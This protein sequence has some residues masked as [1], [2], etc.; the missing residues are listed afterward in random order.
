MTDKHSGRIGSSHAR[1]IGLA[2][3]AL[4]SFLANDP[5]LRDHIS[6][7]LV[8]TKEPASLPVYVDDNGTEMYVIVYA[9]PKKIE[10]SDLFIIMENEND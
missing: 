6:K 8:V 5:H 10:L 4:R 2:G 3:Q 1:E 7:F 9:K